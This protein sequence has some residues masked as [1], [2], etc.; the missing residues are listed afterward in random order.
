MIYLI[1]Y[2]Y[3]ILFS[4]MIPNKAKRAQEHHK[5]FIREKHRR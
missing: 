5:I 3:G 2:L 4:M 1:P